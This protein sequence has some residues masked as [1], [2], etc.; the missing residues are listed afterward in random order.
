M[1]RPMNVN[2]REIIYEGYITKTTKQMYR[3]KI[4]SFK[5]V[6]KNIC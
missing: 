5:Y 1:H 6:I 3:G 2:F 4:L